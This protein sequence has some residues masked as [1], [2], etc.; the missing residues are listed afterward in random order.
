MLF[1]GDTKD[2]R[3]VNRKENPSNRVT[4]RDGRATAPGHDRERGRGR[5][6]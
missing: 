2:K 6:C 5:T 4:H 3:R 1:L